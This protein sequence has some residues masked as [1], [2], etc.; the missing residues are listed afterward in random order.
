[1]SVLSSV[2]GKDAG[3]AVPEYAITA[4]GCQGFKSRE[5]HP[6]MNINRSSG[7]EHWFMLLKKGVSVIKYSSLGH[8]TL[9]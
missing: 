9:S 2:L 7:K 6:K 1:M 4:Y 5:S 3:I 8:I